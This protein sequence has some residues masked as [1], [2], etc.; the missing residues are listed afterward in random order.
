[1]DDG[2]VLY[3]ALSACPEFSFWFNAYKPSVNQTI[4]GLDLAANLTNYLIPSDTSLCRNGSL[5]CAI[6]DLANNM[7]ISMLSN[8]DL[9]T[10]R[11]R[12]VSIYTPCN[13][14]QYNNL[15][16]VLSDATAI[17]V[18][19]CS[20]TIGVYVLYENGV[21]HSTSFSAI[22]NTTHNLQRN[23]LSEGQSLGAEPLAKD[24]KDLKIRLGIVGYEEK[25]IGSVSAIVGQAGFGLEGHVEKLR[26]G[27]ICF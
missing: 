26:Q 11:T 14:Y 16:L 22:M 1:M 8:P 2:N 20:V 3:T 15:T 5:A 19:L 23:E 17:I 21:S 18:T 25:T 27:Q 13:S 12:P 10:N 6:E 9:T 7:T 4:L 24:V